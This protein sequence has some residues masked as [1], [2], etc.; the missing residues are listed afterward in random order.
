MI[1]RSILGWFEIILGILLIVWS[2]YAFVVIMPDT[3]LVRA[4]M[5]I[6]L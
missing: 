3:A 2:I 4:A 5:H 6:T 1:S